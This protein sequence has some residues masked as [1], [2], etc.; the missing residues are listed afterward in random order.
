[1]MQTFLVERDMA[2]IG[3]AVL[4]SAKAAAVRQAQRMTDD[5]D[6][7]D[8]LGS[9]FVPGDGRCL[10]LFRAKNAAVVQTLNRD[11]GLP[12]ERIVAAA[13]LEP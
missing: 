10:C 3:L 1:M 13:L 5:G 8:Y 6:R 4:H 7:V 12:F 11:A 9:T 2:G